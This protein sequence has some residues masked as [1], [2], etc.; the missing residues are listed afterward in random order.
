MGL[1]VY[2]R[3]VQFVEAHL[4]LEPEAPKGVLLAARLGNSVFAGDN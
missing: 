4:A 1:P 3:R 2:R